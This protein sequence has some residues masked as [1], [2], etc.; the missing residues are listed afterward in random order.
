MRAWLPPHRALLQVTLAVV[1]R[2]TSRLGRTWRRL[3]G[4]RRL[5]G[6]GGILGGGED[7]D[8]E[9]YDTRLYGSSH[10][11]DRELAEEAAVEA[12]RQR[13]LRQQQL[14]QEGL[15]LAPY[16]DARTV[17]RGQLQPIPAPP[18]GTAAAAGAAGAAPSSLP[19]RRLALS[20]AGA[21]ADASLE[22][23]HFNG[24]GGRAL[25]AI[26]ESPTLSSSSLMSA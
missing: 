24:S 19:P 13:R 18:M 8:G 22:L 3:D 26:P 23:A 5:V 12:Q 9:G 1:L 17:V 11:S 2:P 25:S 20:A 14:E 4:R 16:E 21:G 7:E 6:G 10:L 15:S